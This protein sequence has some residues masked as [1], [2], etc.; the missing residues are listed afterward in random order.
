MPQEN[1]QIFFIFT[2]AISFTFFPLFL[3]THLPHFNISLPLK[4][5]RY[6]I[7]YDKQ[8]WFLS[9]VLVDFCLEVEM[10]YKDKKGVK[11][12]QKFS[13]GWIVTYVPL[14]LIVYGNYGL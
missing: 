3:A 8:P 13:I 5:E 6:S 12:E 10:K 9:T 1:S 11:M 7:K 14:I 2:F 4:R